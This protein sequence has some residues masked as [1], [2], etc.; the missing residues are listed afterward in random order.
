[1]TR[2]SRPRSCL[3]KVRFRFRKLGARCIDVRWSGPG[4][5]G[6]GLGQGQPL[7]PAAAQIHHGADDPPAGPRAV[8]RRSRPRS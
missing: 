8:T 7:E 3:V 1:M 5:Q 6:Q 4:R 2:W